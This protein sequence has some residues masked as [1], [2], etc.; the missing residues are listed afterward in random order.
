M[1]NQDFV[2]HVGKRNVLPCPLS[3]SQIGTSDF[4]FSICLRTKIYL[5]EFG[6]QYPPRALLSESFCR[7]NGA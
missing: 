2:L 3:G 6:V 7:F 1:Q 5:Q 4:P